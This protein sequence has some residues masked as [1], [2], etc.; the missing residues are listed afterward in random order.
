[1]YTEPKMSSK[2]QF[3]MRQ[4][5]F[6]NAANHLLEPLSQPPNQHE[7][8]QAVV[9]KSYQQ[10]HSSQPEATVS[11]RELQVDVRAAGT[12]PRITYAVDVDVSGTEATVLLWL[13]GPGREGVLAGSAEGTAAQHENVLLLTSPPLPLARLLA[14]AG[15]LYVGG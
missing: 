14:L 9:A 10:L 5:C 4:F 13:P 12:H 2:L 3:G 1:M 7:L 8:P 15:A 6:P 11:A